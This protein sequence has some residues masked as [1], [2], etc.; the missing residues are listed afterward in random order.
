MLAIWSIAF[1]LM[2]GCTHTVQPINTT[3][4]QKPLIEKLPI[5]VGSYYSEQLRSYENIQ[6]IP[7]SDGHK[8]KFVMGPPSI[9]LFDQVFQNIFE[10]VYLV[11]SRPQLSENEQ[12][13]RAV[14]EPK[15]KTLFAD[16]VSTSAEVDISYDIELYDVIGTEIASWS[17][18]GSGYSDGYGFS[19]SGLARRAAQEALYDVASKFIVEF[20]KHPKVLKWLQSVKI[21]KTSGAKNAYAINI[22]KTKN[23]M[24][25]VIPLGNRSTDVAGCVQKALKRTCLDMKFFPSDEFVKMLYPWFEPNTAPESQEDLEAMLKSRLVQDRIDKI[26]VR[27]AITITGETGRSYSELYRTGTGTARAWTEINASVFDLRDAK[28]QAIAESSKYKKRD[29]LAWPINLAPVIIGTEY[30]VCKEIGETI[31][32]QLSGCDLRV[33]EEDNYN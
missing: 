33:D 12:K 21:S 16:I 7:A 19:Y 27:Y 10:E 9:T 13:I 30:P 4:P 20:I 23:K 3:L 5:T 28:L 29:Y 24:I 26:G 11:Q 31:A 15:I 17:I 32:Q 22:E 25:T 18:T 6:R 8:V 1:F 2:I 14:I